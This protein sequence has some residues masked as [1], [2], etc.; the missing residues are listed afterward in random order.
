MSE[1]NLYDN[2]LI[3]DCGVFVNGDFY[4][5]IS[6]SK[7]SKVSE[8]YNDETQYL[9]YTYKRSGYEF[10]IKLNN[11]SCIE[12]SLELTCNQYINYTKKFLFIE[13]DARKLNPEYDKFFD[14]VKKKVEN[15]RK[16][17]ILLHDELTERYIQWDKSHRIEIGTK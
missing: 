12:L 14:N 8:I 5:F 11:K 4:P 7:I 13:Q 15:N 16:A 6:F 1:K 17:A 10:Y 3:E 2:I 9:G